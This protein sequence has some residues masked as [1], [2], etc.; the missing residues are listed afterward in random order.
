MRAGRIS[1]DPGFAPLLWTQALTALH[2]NLLRSAV[3]TMIAFG[4]VDTG[5]WPVETVV[6][7]TT[8][9]AVLPY[10]L[11]SLSAGRW[12]DRWSRA[13]VIRLCKLAEVAIAGVAAVGLVSG[14]LAILLGAVLLCGIEAAVLGPAKFA[15]LPELV[16]ARRLVAANS[17]V[18]ATST[19]AILLGLVLGNLLVATPSGPVILSMIGFALALAGLALS[20]SIPAADAPPPGLASSAWSDTARVLTAVTQQ[21][22]VLLAILGCSWFWFQGAFNTTAIPL[23]IAALGQGEVAVSIVF[24]TSSVCVA[25]GA[26]MARL[27]QG[28]LTH[29][30]V[31]A[32]VALMTVLPAIDIGL[33]AAAQSFPRLLIDI[34]LMSIASGLFIV[35]VGLAMQVLPPAADRGRYIG[36]NHLVNGLAM[37]LSGACVAALG[38]LSVRPDAAIGSIGV[39]SACVAIVTLP[40]LLP[41]LT[42][43][44]TRSASEDGAG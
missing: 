2:H 32:A 42:A 29:P 12:T 11:L 28:K 43:L 34:A 1:A 38:A 27:V 10:V 36:I 37:L 23:L 33:F 22:S 15:I 24:L 39:M 25:G 8:I 21:R 20:R 9:V 30:A 7:A 17:W 41:S 3:L 35:P 16:E 26:V 6:G 13:G 40:A 4:A 18:T 31:P 19:I 44:R 14:N 5:A